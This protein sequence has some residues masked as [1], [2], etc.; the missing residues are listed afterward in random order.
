MLDLFLSCPAAHIQKVRGR[1]AGVLN[2]VH[3]RHGQARAVHHAG[4]GAIQLDV[5]E[6]VLA[7]FHFQRI[8]LGRIAQR[9]DVRMAEER[10]VVKVDLRV[11]GEQLVV[12]GGDEGIDFDQRGVRIDDRL[13]QA[14][15]EAHRL[16]NLRGLQAQREGQL[17]CLPCAKAHCRVD[18]LLEDGLRRFSRDL[19]NLHAAGLR[20][21][22]HQLAR[23]AVQHNAQVE[24]A[25]NRRG[26]FDK[27]TL[28]L[29]PL[30][31]GL[32]RHQLHAQ[33]GL[34]IALGILARFGH[35]HAAALAAAS[36]MNLR[37]H[38]NARS[39]L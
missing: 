26:L 14:L 35:L 13:V 22:K 24:L 20:S 29:L 5:V 37:L 19:F 18:R 36:G 10:V 11:E 34:G 2:N 3:R 12:L 31:P 38:H 8:F 9:L 28:H 4:N 32:V 25:V 33:D 21:H 23:G 15:E 1:A 27:Q 30:R 16:I 7:R 17:A 39:A 6:R